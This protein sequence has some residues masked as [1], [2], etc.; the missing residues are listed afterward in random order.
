[1]VGSPT[2]LMGFAFILEQ[3]AT[4]ATYTINWLVLVTEMESV[5]C[6]VRTGSLEQSAGSL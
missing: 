1:M 2:V 5:Y 6:V 4:C 3:T